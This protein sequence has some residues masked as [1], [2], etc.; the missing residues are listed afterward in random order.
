M[1]GREF[2]PRFTHPHDSGDSITEH[3]ENA[4]TPEW[5]DCTSVR[6][7]DL[8]EEVIKTRQILHERREALCAEAGVEYD[9][10]SSVLEGSL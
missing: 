6:S 10:E 9:C 1:K 7:G 5:M 2:H 8:M 4:T 3:W